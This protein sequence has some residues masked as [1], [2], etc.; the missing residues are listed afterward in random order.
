[1]NVR[2]WALIAFSILVQMSV[3]SFLVLGLIHF[4]AQ[5][6]AGSAEAD[7]LSDR[8][9]LAIGPVLGFGLVASLL[10]LGNPL[11]AFRAVANVGSSWLSREILF[12][13]LFAVTGAAFAIGQWFKI[14][15]F[16]VRN[17]LALLAAVLGLALV[18]S[19]ANVYLLPTVP[20][21]NTWTTP[22]S[23]FVSTFLLGALAMG[24]AFVANYAYL[25][26]MQPGCAEAQCALLRGSLRWIALASLALLGI[27]FVITPLQVASLVGQGEV[28]RA[29]ASM[30]IE[31]FG[32]VFVLRLVLVFAGAGV[33]GV[34]VYR[35]ALRAGQEQVL[36]FLTYAAFLL[37]LVGEVLGRFLFYA[38]FART[39]I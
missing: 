4:F 21:W 25:K 26:R 6:S 11:N 8:A 38:T 34:F 13:V 3:G 10:H 32:V 37:V 29:S 22:V 7:R 12:G 27:E 18:Y 15:T 35:N 28:S 30:M 36:G 33:L 2:E 5:R 24:A 9:L 14:S 17:I 16:A 20:A 23:F 1:M 39:G 19:M 31:P